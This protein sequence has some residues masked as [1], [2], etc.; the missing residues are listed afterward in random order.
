MPEYC[1]SNDDGHVF[2]R[3]FKM[4]DAPSEV[5]IISQ[6]RP[7][8]YKRDFQAEQVGRPARAGW[9]LTCFASGVNANQAQELRDHFKEAGVP[10]EVTVNGD[11]VY[12]S[13]AHRKRALACRG[14]Y[15]KASF[16]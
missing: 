3:F 4:G 16:C 12:T 11:C 1:Y 2:E 6:G 7:A 14:I 13:H 15:D 9:P 10:T 5:V 8:V